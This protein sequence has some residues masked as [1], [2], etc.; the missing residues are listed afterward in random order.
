R[1]KFKKFM[2][3]Q[4]LGV[5]LADVFCL[6]DY[7]ARGVF[8]VTLASEALCFDVWRKV[9]EKKDEDPVKLFRVEP[10]FAGE[11]TVMMVHVFDSF[12]PEKDIEAF[13]QQ[14]VD[15]QGAGKR[16]LDPD[17][18]WN[19]KRTYLMRLRLGKTAE[20]GVIHPPAFFEIGTHRGYLVYPGQPLACMVCGERG[21][22]ASQCTLVSCKRCGKTGHVAR[23]CL[24]E[25][26]CYLC[27]EPGHVYQCCIKNVKKSVNVN[28]VSRN[29]RDME[30]EGSDVQGGIYD[31]EDMVVYADGF[32]DSDEERQYSD[33]VK[34]CELDLEKEGYTGILLE[35]RFQGDSGIDSRTNGLGSAERDVSGVEEGSNRLKFRWV[36]GDAGESVSGLTVD[37]KEEGNE[38]GEVK[39]GQTV[40]KKGKKKGKG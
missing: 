30:K 36:N 13:L 17:G 33:F 4:C 6:Q 15:L 40:R 28:C 29:V 38:K 27:D 8:E 9:Q 35:G 32:I 14:F 22:F 26:K 1:D 12:V 10:M 20:E 11:L 23:N 25:K 18:V 2:L 19:G 24:Q 34:S 39:V 31:S 21:H 7:C 16:Q 5:N 3:I 37:G